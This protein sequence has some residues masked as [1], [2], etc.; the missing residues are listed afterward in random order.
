MTYVFSNANFIALLDIELE[1]IA[2]YE[3]QHGNNKTG[4]D[5]I[6]V[7]LLKAIRDDLVMELIRL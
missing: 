2:T 1:L 4:V 5:Q 3:V 7:E 6:L